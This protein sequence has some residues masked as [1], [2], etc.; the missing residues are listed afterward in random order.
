MFCKNKTFPTVTDET[1]ISECPS[2]A[3]FKRNT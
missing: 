2:F 3:K 1:R